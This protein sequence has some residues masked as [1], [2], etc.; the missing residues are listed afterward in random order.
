MYLLITNSIAN[1]LQY[2]LDT[3]IIIANFAKVLCYLLF[4]SEVILL[5]NINT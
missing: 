1:K 5:L 4:A 2:Q 3:T